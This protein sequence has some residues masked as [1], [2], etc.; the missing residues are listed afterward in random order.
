MIKQNS[1][2]TLKAFLLVASGVVA[3]G[4]SNE[5]S[6]A[7]DRGD[8]GT[9]G[10]SSATT[11]TCEICECQPD[12]TARPSDVYEMVDTLVS[13]LKDQGDPGSTYLGV[14]PNHQTP[15]WSVPAIG[16]N[17]AK[18]EIGCLGDFQLP[19]P[20]SDPLDQIVQAQVDY[21]NDW[22][23]PDGDLPKAAGV[24]LSCKSAT[25]LAGPIT[26]AI[27]AG[28][29]VITMDSDSVDSGR[30]MYMGTLN[31][32]A[33]QLAGKEMLRMLNDSASA[34][35]LV[36][37]GQ[38]TETN[39]N[40]RIAGITKAFEDAGRADELVVIHLTSDSDVQ[41]SLDD[42]AAQ[43]GADLGGVLTLNGTFGP[44]AADWVVS[45]GLSGTTKLVAWDVST[46]TKTHISNGV[47]QAA[48]AQKSYFF[49][50]LP[51]YVL[52]AMS[53][54]GVDETRAVL[55]P[56]L[57]GPNHDLLDTG[58]DLITAKNLEDYSSYQKDCLGVTGG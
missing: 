29:N 15:F 17:Q 53:A 40:D 2:R 31:E 54:L 23:T 39:S 4:C 55:D 10:A 12:N 9:A 8:N 28:V 35:A 58:V 5:S 52:Y 26:D 32:P 19:P 48:L 27:A 36:L 3:L 46:A 25:A 51:M 43:Y 33:G 18:G 30:L 57:S 47:I 56:F 34:I 21:L 50:Y 49:G 37:G 44:I 16:F 11:A 22:T 14:M 24:A 6:N 45:Q 41:T 20:K 7:P 38:A 13:A 1:S 42:A